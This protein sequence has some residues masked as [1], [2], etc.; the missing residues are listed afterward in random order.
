MISEIQE[1]T[2]GWINSMKTHIKSL[3][4][5][6]RDMKEEFVEGTEILKKM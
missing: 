5:T 2:K 4:K 3:M 1:D 6:I